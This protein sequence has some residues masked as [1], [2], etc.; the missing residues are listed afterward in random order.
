MDT[1]PITLLERLRTPGDEDAWRQLVALVTP[2]LLAW[3]RRVG[4]RREDAADLAQDVLA[5]LVQK[6]PTF[7]YDP[8]QSFRA[9]LKTIAMNKWR[10]RLRRPAT[11]SLDGH[12][13]RL[14]APDAE[15][16]WEKEYR[17]QL[18]LRAFEAIKDDF[19]P[20]TWQACRELVVRGRDVKQ[21]AAELGM[22]ADAVYVAKCRVL[23]RL[24]KELD[25]MLE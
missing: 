13:D 8:A 6:L 19:Q 20:R 24:R 3:A 15:A 1:T 25:G 17:F 18:V 21:V 14:A 7:D 22:S 4:M 5:I 9:W 12:L 23:R 2:L 16:A 10:E 11:Q